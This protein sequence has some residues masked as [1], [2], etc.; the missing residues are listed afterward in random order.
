MRNWLCNSKR[1]MKMIPIDMRDIKEIYQRFRHA[2]ITNRTS[3][4]PFLEEKRSTKRE[5]LI[6]LM[7]LFDNAHRAL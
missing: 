3:S 7:S 4:W 5:V 6:I 2:K 1:V